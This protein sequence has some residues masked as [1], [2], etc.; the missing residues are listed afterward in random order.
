MPFI[1]RGINLLGI[2]SGFFVGDLRRQLWQRVTRDL[3]PRHL[4]DIAQ[5]IPFD[6][7]PRAFDQFLSGSVRGR[8]VVRIATAS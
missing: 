7:L 5:T 4:S 8:I 1:L 3:R 2:N 6:A